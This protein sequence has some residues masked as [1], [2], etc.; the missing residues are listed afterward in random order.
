MTPETAHAVPHEAH[1]T[2]AARLAAPRLCGI[3]LL[4]GWGD[5]VEALTGAP[6][7]TG[8]VPVATPAATGERFRRAT[9]ECLLGVSVASAALRDAGLDGTALAG[10]R[11]GIVYVTAAGYGSANRA[12]LEEEGSGTLH[13]PYTAPSAVP[14][15]VTIEFGMR[16]PCVNLMGGATAA[17]LGFWYAARWLADGCADR[18]LVLAVETMHEVR[19][20]FARGRRLYDGP[21]VEGAA[22][23][24]LEPGAGDCLAWASVTGSRPSVAPRVADVLEA[25]VGG[26]APSF[27]ASGAG[28]GGSGRA[29]ARWLGERD[30]AR[31][32]P[33]SALP[34]ET[35]ACAPLIGLGRAR[36]AGV[37]GPC[38]LTAAWRSE[39]GAMLWPL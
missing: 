14:G 37:R 1:A 31:R 12:F 33:L 25:V 27:V 3:G 30:I 17:L 10:D 7:V 8:L 18:V 4:T 11:A 28:R 29:E 32:V 13:F 20:L 15:E 22:C 6:A 16:G 36:A 5:G 39:Y 9:R 38:L 23:V 34:G 24:L 26:E 2:G 21:L 19:G 35:L